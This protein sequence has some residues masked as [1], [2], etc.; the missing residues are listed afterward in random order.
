MARRQAVAVAEGTLTIGREPG[1]VETELKLS[2]DDEQP[3]RRLAEVPNIGPI[4]LGSPQTYLEV[5]RYLDTDDARLAGARWACR[6]RSRGR[7]YRVSL[8]GPP[9]TTNAL[10][11]AL[12]RRP[13]IEGPASAQP[14]PAAWPASDAR[15]RLV[16]LA[17][18]RPLEEWFT[19]RQARTQRPVGAETRPIGTLSLDRVTVIRNSEPLGRLWC[20]ELELAG[21]GSETAHGEGLVMLPGLLADLLAGGGLAVEPMTKL[22]RALALFGRVPS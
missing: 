16:E 18:G 14:D 11:G 5:D 2:A 3:L 6:L 15:D 19:L 8:K 1:A 4:S 17:G 7:T 10:G 12:H 13:E 20:V 22:E 9:V 21:G